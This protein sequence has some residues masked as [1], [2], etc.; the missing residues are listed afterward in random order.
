MVR[1]RLHVDKTDRAL[2]NLIRELDAKTD[3][4]VQRLAEIGMNEATAH[5]DRAAMSEW[6]KDTGEGFMHTPDIAVTV[7]PR[8]RGYAIVA[9]GREVVFVEFGA[10]VYYNGA[11]SYL[12]ERPPEVA[13]I[14][15]YGQGKGS[16]RTWGFE[17]DGEIVLT[18]GNPPANAMYYATEE[19]RRRIEEVAREVF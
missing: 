11:E 13:G 15:E 5:F 7:E 4:F 8:E 10:G 17:R 18:H 1:F 14:G 3:L 2:G 9:S 12:G 19:M 6:Y 16:Q